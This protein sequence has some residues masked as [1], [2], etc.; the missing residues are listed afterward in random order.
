MDTLE[1]LPVANIEDTYL[2]DAEFNEKYPQHP[3]DEKIPQHPIE[4]QQ[5]ETEPHV[6]DLDE[7]AEFL[8]GQD[9]NE[10]SLANKDKQLEMDNFLIKAVFTEETEQEV[11][12]IQDPQTE[13]HK[14][15]Q[16]C[17]F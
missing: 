5:I 9:I 8:D 12:V 6:M 7:F 4:E 1:E 13:A 16:V 15:N 10:Q 14:S 3:I 11:Q 17:L 2:T